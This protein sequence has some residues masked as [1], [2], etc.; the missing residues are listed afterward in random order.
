MDLYTQT[1]YENATQLTLRYSSSFSSSSRLFSPAIRRYI[2]GIYGF[3]RIADEI[4]DTYKGPHAAT[5]LDEL[6]HDAYRAIKLGYSANPIVHAFADAARR[7]QIDTVLIAPFF[8]SM[9]LDLQ[10]R[11]YTA[12][13]YSRYIH[14]SAEVVGLMCL[15]VF[16]GQEQSLY[17]ALRPGAEKLGAAYQKVNFLRD[18]ASDYQALGRLYFPGV[19]YDQFDEAAKA[20]V[21][22][23]ITADFAAAYPAIVQLPTTSRGAVMTSY[24]YYRS[25]LNKLD[26][27]SVETIK[28]SRLRLSSPAKLALLSSAIVRSKIT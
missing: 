21:I 28:T 12:A 15:R 14:G 25:L 27:A 11:R 19:T 26:R 16:C 6:E 13:M 23:D 4:V 10:P 9:R 20:A 5:I 24:V 8:D 22:A 17:A 1:A 7:F 18:L 3:V 2:Y